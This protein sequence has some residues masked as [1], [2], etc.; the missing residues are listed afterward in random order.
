MAGLGA[1][2]KG[3]TRL[4]LILIFLFGPWGWF[5]TPFYFYF[6]PIFFK[7]FKYFFFKKKVL[8]FSI[9]INFERFLFYVFLIFLHYDTCLILGVDTYQIVSF[10]TK[11]LTEVPIP[12]FPKP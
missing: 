6:F 12:S 3:Q 2:S 5:G 1:T 4:I 8:L 7:V 9:F 10:W 11:K